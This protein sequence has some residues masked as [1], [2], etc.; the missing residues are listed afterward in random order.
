M[1]IRHRIVSGPAALLLLSISMLLSACGDSDVKEVKQWMADVDRSTK[2]AIQP[3]SEPK[4]FVPFAY[5]A[6][7]AVDPY[8][9]NKLLVELA[10]LSDQSTNPL[11]PDL[12][13]RKE[14]L[15]AYPLDTMHMV[16]IIQKNGVNYALVQ[17]NGA[18]YQVVNGQRIGQNFGIVTGV[19][20]DTI[21]IK[22]VLQ[23]AGGD[24]VERMSKLELQVS[25][26]TTK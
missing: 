11:K 19:T 12:N 13:R 18:V 20:E 7:D 6:K 26:E 25:K 10:K 1:T 15:E 9:P 4:N 5:G 8:S 3:L 23:D 14:L 17:I 16:G 24:W 21:N 2:V 22:E